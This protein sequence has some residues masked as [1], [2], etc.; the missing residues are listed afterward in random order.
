M[1]VVLYFVC[2]ENKEVHFNMNETCAAMRLIDIVFI[3]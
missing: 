1:N 2:L 3:F